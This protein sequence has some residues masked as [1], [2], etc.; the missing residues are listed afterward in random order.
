[1]ITRPLGL[2]SSSGCSTSA[3][4]SCRRPGHSAR[5]KVVTAA[6]PTSPH[7]LLGVEA[8][9]DE[10]T[11]K[12]AFRKLALQH[13]PDVSKQEGAEV[14]FLQL[15]EAYEFLLKK[16]RGGD[17]PDESSS[18]Q[19]DGWDFHDWYWS[20][21]MNRSWAKKGRA[22]AA[23]ASA[24]AANPLAEEAADLRDSEGLYT[25]ASSSPSDCSSD[26]S[27]ASAAGYKAPHRPPNSAGKIREQLAGLRHRSAVRKTRRARPPPVCGS[28]YDSSAFAAGGGEWGMMSTIGS[29]EETDV[30]D[31]APVV[32]EPQQP[33]PQQQIHY[34]PSEASSEAMAAE[35]DSASTAAGEGEPSPYSQTKRKFVAHSGTREQVVGQLAGLRRKAHFAKQ[36]AS[37]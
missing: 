1:M 31:E 27:S 14:R 16:L 12:K 19:A 28:D 34:Q 21:R 32:E 29:W 35:A 26:C 18:H 13:H 23:A 4:A 15:A 33:Q 30:E 25:D 7:T 17:E 36:M 9:S 8:T 20:F 5:T 10:R 2:Y 3:L 22:A 24:A 6:L 37:V 11:I